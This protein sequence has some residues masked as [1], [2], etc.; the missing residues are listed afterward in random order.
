[1]RL[2]CQHQTVM[3][4]VGVF[5]GPGSGLRS[6][7]DHSV[8]PRKLSGR[9]YYP[10]RFPC[11]EI[12][13]WRRRALLGLKAFA[14]PICLFSP[15]WHLS[16]AFIL[17]VLDMCRFC[18]ALSLSLSQE[19]RCSRLDQ[20]LVLF[21]LTLRASHPDHGRG[22]QP[23][24]ARVCGSAAQVGQGV[25]VQQVLRGLTLRPEEGRVRCSPSP[26]QG[27]SWRPAVWS[28]AFGITEHLCS[29]L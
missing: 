16:L 27:L 11:G 10:H 14:L 7:W 21:L 25:H 13:G 18:V 28:L 1:M 22:Q 26:T 17:N 24:W 29:D 23:G 5:S 20:G 2:I 3:S 9:W 19:R 8:F 12:E 15:P 6:L 4:L